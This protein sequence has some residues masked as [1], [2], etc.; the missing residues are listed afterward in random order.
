M[1]QLL[2]HNSCSN[3]EKYSARCLVDQSIH[4]STEME[5]NTLYEMMMLLV[6]EMAISTSLCLA[7]SDYQI[8]KMFPVLS[9]IHFLSLVVCQQLSVPEPCRDQPS[10][11]AFLFLA[12]LQLGKSYKLFIHWLLAEILWMVINSRNV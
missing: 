5:V 10:C 6:P 4:M 9:Q 3:C 2:S 12:R 8:L 11:F 1:L 7:M